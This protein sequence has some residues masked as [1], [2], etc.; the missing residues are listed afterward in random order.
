VLDEA[1]AL[2][3]A[4]VRELNLVGQDITRF[5]EGRRGGGLPG[6]VRAVAALPGDFR[7][8]LLYLH[9]ERVDDAVIDLFAATPK[10]CA[11]LDVPIQHASTR[12]LR[13]MNRRYGRRDLERLFSTLRGRVPGVALRTTVMVGYP[14][15]GRREFA[16][17]LAFLRAHPFENLGAFTFSPQPGTRAAAMAGAAPQ[18]EAEA[19]YHE[20]MTLQAS[21]ASDLWERRVGQETEAL[22]LAPEPG[23]TTVWTA[24][25]PWQAPEVDGRIRVRGRGEAGRWVAVRVT[26]AGA[27]DLEGRVLPTPGRPTAPRRCPRP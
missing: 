17:L 14:G 1:R 12:V 16:E 2:I 6:L 21:L 18:E 23:R 22:L 7:V 24:R 19:R 20:V 10:L 4:G 13:R 25:T 8:R 3:D 11:Y 15:E 27:Y 26:G 5:G 9:P